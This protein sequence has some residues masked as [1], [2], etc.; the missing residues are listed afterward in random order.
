MAAKIMST[1]KKYYS[2]NAPSASIRVYNAYT[3]SD[4]YRI[5][6]NIGRDVFRNTG[7]KIGRPL[8]FRG[9]EKEEYLLLPSL[10]RK[11]G[12]EKNEAGFYSKLSL[13]EEYRHQ[14]FSARV[15]HL[16]R[17]NLK[18]RVEWQE[19]IQHH[20]G[21]TRFMDWSE[22]LEKAVYFALEPFIDTKDTEDNRIRRASN[23]PGIWVLNPY[24]LNEHVYDF[25]S[26]KANEKYVTRALS[27]LFTGS[28]LQYMAKKFQRELSKNKGIYFNYDKK[29][30]IDVAI[31]GMVSVCILDEHY[32][33]N[34]ADM[35]QMLRRQEFNPFFYLVVR[36][37]ADALPVDADVNADFLPP[38]ASVQPYHSE[39]IQAQR[40]TFTIF[41][42][43]CR[44]ENAKSLADTKM[45]VIAIESQKSIA[46]CFCNIRFCDPVRI[47]K[48][49]I[50]AGSRRPDAYPDIQVYADYLETKEMFL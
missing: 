48:E 49:L 20:F 41:P 34:A 5:L 31:N 12:N 17:T 10:Y 27:G 30:I 1:L 45:D 38:L 16:T 8:W 6:G 14:N 47:A 46:D 9:Q 32:H 25:F 3:M 2:S 28:E 13:A 40:G 21:K 22:S 19:V 35:K 18:S 44:T 50:Y 39:R 23:T 33:Y 37:Y 4:V 11:R 29:E 15:N 43:Y 7:E 42:N 24:K 26:D 36:Y